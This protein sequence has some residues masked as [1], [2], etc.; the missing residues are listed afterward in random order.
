MLSSS[1]Y[2]TP[3]FVWFPTIFFCSYTS[4]SKLYC[5]DFMAIISNEIWV[6]FHAIACLA[7]LKNYFVYNY[8]ALQFYSCDDLN[9]FLNSCNFL[10]GI[11][12]FEN[13][14]I[15]F[16]TWFFYLVIHH[17]QLHL[18]FTSLLITY[19]YHLFYWFTN[20]FICV[21]CYSS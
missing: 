11:T 12:S 4:A 8:F 16:F 20:N 6:L 5:N 2:S 10:W 21:S 19:F 15:F 9:Y 14:F 3:P 17:H 13:I 7:V 1:T 18:C